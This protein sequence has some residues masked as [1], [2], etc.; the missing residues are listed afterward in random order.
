[1]SEEENKFTQLCV[2]QGTTL[3]GST[4]EDFVK[5]FEEQGFR[6]KYAEEVN[7]NPDLDES[8]NAVPETGGRT[9]QLFFI[10]TDDVTKFAMPKLQMGIRWWEDVVSYNDNSHLYPQEVLDKYPVTW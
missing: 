4:P 2:W 10:H 1:M 7:T 9:D 6:I 3:G 5:F 8:G